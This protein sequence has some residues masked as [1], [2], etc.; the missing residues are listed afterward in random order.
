MRFPNAF[1]G[2][3]KLFKSEI[4]TI[5]GIVCMILAA[6]FGIL[7]AS[8]ADADEIGSALGFGIGALVFSLGFAVLSIIAFIMQL[9]GLNIAALDEPKFKTALVFVLLGIAGSVLSG[10]NTERLAFLNDVGT[11]LTNISSIFIIY[12]VIQ[13]VSS[14]AAVYGNEAIIKKGKTIIY[15][16]LGVYICSLIAS[17]LGLFV[18]DGTAAAV[19]TL[20]ASVLTLVQYILYLTFLSDAKKMLAE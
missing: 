7:T 6:F 11:I 9:R 17:I 20:I 13:G 16:I 8:L 14:L 1:E 12:Y 4:L 18:L 10:L 2:V 19:V 5:I 15:M 3:K